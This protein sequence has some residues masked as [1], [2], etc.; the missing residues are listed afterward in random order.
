VRDATIKNFKKS[1]KQIFAVLALVPLLLPLGPVGALAAVEP[2]KV[3]D[4]EAARITATYDEQIVVKPSS[5]VNI[6]LAPS[7]FQLEQARK[8]KL[9]AATSATKVTQEASYEEKMSWVKKAAEAYGIDW[10]LLAAVWQTESGQRWYSNVRSSA[11]ACG[12]CQ[13]MAGTWRAYGQDGNGDGTRDIAD[14]RD[15]LF[16][17]AKLLVANGAASGRVTEALLRYNHSMAY[18][19][20]V[21][22]LAESY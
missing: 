6:Q 2:T 11:G 19:A 18:V 14:A 21:L 1:T 3:V 12:P 4:T 10:K 8:A 20:K 9:L 7:A 13:F 22:K 15:C 16:G 17:A 5:A